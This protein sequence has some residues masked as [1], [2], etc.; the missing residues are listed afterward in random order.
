MKNQ[1]QSYL[2]IGFIVIL[3]II[4]LVIVKQNWP[5]LSQIIPVTNLVMTADNWKTYTDTV[6]GFSLKYPSYYFI[7]RGEPNLGFVLT[8]V[9]PKEGV[10][11]LYLGENDARFGAS[12]TSTDIPL[13]EYLSKQQ[14]LFKNIQKNISK[15]A[16]MIDGVSGYKVISA[17]QTK[18][19]GNSNTIIYVSEGLAMKNGK[20]YSVSLSSFNQKL[21]DSKQ[22]MFDQ[23]LSTFRF[24]TPLKAD[25]S[26]WTNFV[27]NTYSFNIKFPITYEV[28]PGAEE[29]NTCV[30]VKLSA[31]ECVVLINIYEDKDNLTLDSYLNK[32]IDSFA[33]SGPLV[34]YDF[35]GYDSLL[36]KN[37][38]GTELFIK[39][40]S[41]V[42]RFTASKA[43]SDKEVGDIMATFRFASPETTTTGDKAIAILQENKSIQYIQGIVID[44]G[45]KAYLEKQS[46][47]DNVVEIS[48]IEDGFPDKHT[49][50]IDTF[51]V[52]VETGEI[53]VVNMVNNKNISLDEWA[54]EVTQRFPGGIK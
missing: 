45:R 8:T 40:G 21:L 13:D 38:P 42:Y 5:F 51:Q 29:Q 28:Q 1:K 52:N 23:I 44:R 7:Y 27:N 15:K 12:A 47:K 49:T 54:A 16:I 11:Q 26:S 4:G 20:R 18:P 17:F 35:N 43:S 46:E 31:G 6:S 36:S 3:C 10:N 33:I 41:S 34:S 32:N 14:A 25:T 53:Q 24:V 37:Q 9:P 48:L 50:R 22:I 19:E 39:R 2:S 30:R